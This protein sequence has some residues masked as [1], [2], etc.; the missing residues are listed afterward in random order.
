[1]EI[2]NFVPPSFNIA[3]QTP[4]ISG[5]GGGGSG[6]PSILSDSAGTNRNDAVSKQQ[7]ADDLVKLIQD[8]VQPDIWR[9]NGGTAS[10]RYFNGHL[11][12]T[13]PRSVHEALSASGR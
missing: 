2:P 10:I 13:A 11:I 5:G 7:R 6:G 8:T 9:E 1:M 4:Q 12:V 3:G